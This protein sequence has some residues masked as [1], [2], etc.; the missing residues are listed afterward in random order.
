MDSVRGEIKHDTV[1]YKHKYISLKSTGRGRK[2]TLLSPKPNITLKIT[3]KWAQFTYCSLHLL[4]EN[5]SM[6]DESKD[7]N[8]KLIL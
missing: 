3:M 2:L 4:P 5:S 6:L 1:T 7:W 8:K